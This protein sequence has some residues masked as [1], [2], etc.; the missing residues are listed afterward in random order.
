MLAGEY[1]GPEHGEQSNERRRAAHGLV[2]H[3]KCVARIG[4]GCCL[5]LGVALGQLRV[6]VRPQRARQH[7]M[8]S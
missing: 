3:L 6:R 2:R 1:V 7:L 4:L 5:A 8:V